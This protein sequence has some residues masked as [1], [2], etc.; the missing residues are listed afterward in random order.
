M[1][2]A[3]FIPRSEPADAPPR[4]GVVVQNEV[5]D[6]GS[7]F[8][9]IQEIIAGGQA[10]LAQAQNLAETAPTFPLDGVRLLAP[11]PQPRRNIF[12]V[13][14]NYLA[15][16]HEG[17]GRRG[18]ADDE[19]LPDYPTFFTKATTAANGPY[20]DIPWRSSWTRR[21]DYEAELAVVIGR[22]GRD[23]PQEK[24]LQHVFGYMA[25]NDISA[26]DLQRRHG[27]QWVKGKSLDGSC[28]MGPWLVTADAIPDPQNLHISC[29]VNG[30]LRQE[31]RTNQMIF[32]VAKIIA[33][34]SHG[35]TLLPGDI[36][37]TGTPA[38]V[39]F[40]MD[41]PVYLQ[42]EDQVE[43]E[44]EGIGTIRNRVVALD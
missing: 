9:G 34:L 25:A 16:F 37:L 14:W 41:P 33:E 44:I 10:A 27:G 12:C 43:V 17:Q 2:L 5:A 8:A 36:V 42:A 22:S 20:D 31:A 40:A 26:R 18:I 11:L 13:G 7:Q 30:R 39:G 35:L 38:G 4:P 1:R 28:P 29:R 24:A 6:L 21:L 15:H 32:S 3:T 19:E 23:I